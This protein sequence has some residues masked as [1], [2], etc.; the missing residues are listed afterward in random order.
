MSNYNN[1]QHHDKKYGLLEQ[2][3]LFYEITVVNISRF[4]LYNNKYGVCM[5]LSIPQSHKN[6]WTIWDSNIITCEIN[7]WPH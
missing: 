6:Y 7:I 4:N 3:D 5:V 1:V 2:D